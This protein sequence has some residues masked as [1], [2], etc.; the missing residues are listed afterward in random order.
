MTKIERSRTD[1]ALLSQRLGQSFEDWP[2]ALTL[3]QIGRLISPTY[4][5][6]TDPWHELYERIQAA[7]KCGELEM[8]GPPAVGA[9]I[10]I[11]GMKRFAGYSLRTGEARFWN[12]PPTKTDAPTITPQ[13]LACY[14]GDRRLP[15]LLAVW[16]A[17]CTLPCEE[18]KTPPQAPTPQ[19]TVMQKKRLLEVLGVAYHELHSEFQRN[20]KWLRNCRTG[21]RGYYYL[22]D[23]EAHCADKWPGRIRTPL[24]PGLNLIQQVRGMR[25]GKLT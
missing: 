23:V 7:V 9:G 2:E 5:K 15:E 8:D 19:K 16:L 18:T 17:P 6:H 11:A 10:S 25:G 1:L 14:L 13:T 20:E 4:W 24:S 12:E 3:K 22:E 21:K